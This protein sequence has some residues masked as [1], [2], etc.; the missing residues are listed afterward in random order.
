MCFLFENPKSGTSPEVS[1]VE[2]I[3]PF[4]ERAKEENMCLGGVLTGSSWTGA[5]VAAL[6][7]EMSPLRTLR[8]EIS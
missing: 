8:L 4:A 5:E 7:K 2:E 3:K 1:S 6:D